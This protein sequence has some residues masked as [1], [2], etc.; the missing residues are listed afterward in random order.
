MDDFYVGVDSTIDRVIEF[1][2]FEQM[3]SIGR[4]FKL[5]KKKLMNNEDF[6]L[7]INENL[8]LEGESY[9][10]G[11]AAIEVSTFNSL[12]MNVKFAGTYSKEIFKMENKKTRNFIPTISDMS[13]E[14]KDGVISYIIQ[15]RGIPSRFILEYKPLKSFDLAKNVLK[16]IKLKKPKFVSIVG[17]HAM[18]F[19]D[20]T[21][22][23]I[24]KISDSSI[25]FSDLVPF[26][27]SESKVLKSIF[28]FKIVSMNEFEYKMARKFIGDRRKIMSK[29]NVDILFI[30]THTYQKT[31][32]KNEKWKDV[33]RRAQEFAVAAGTYRIENMSY[34][35]RRSIETILNISTPRSSFGSNFVKTK[36]LKPK[37]II[38]TVGAGDVTFASYISYIMR[39][40]VE[41]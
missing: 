21:V 5:A 34:P 39:S 2:N 7:R 20:E 16:K 19:D 22:E 25:A 30:H 36:T 4:Y 40:G 31:Y 3:K 33:V 12:G 26:K 15:L 9:I 38:S 27:R 32:V 10:G 17:W 13:R 41:F 24:N 14:M 35:T 28:N 37:R 11:N 29:Y 6:A 8:D 23:L 1:K 18:K